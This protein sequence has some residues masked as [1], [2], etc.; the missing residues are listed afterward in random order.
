MWHGARESEKTTIFEN[1]CSLK[2]IK[3]G[4]KI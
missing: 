2:E 1:N 3:I 4:E